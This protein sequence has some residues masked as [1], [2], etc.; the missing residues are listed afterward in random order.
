[1]P[2]NQAVERIFP[3]WARKPADAR[4][5]AFF[6]GAGLALLDA[7]L[8]E[9]PP[10][11]GALRQRLA[12]RAATACA[13]MAR[14][15]DDASGLRDAEHLAPGAETTQTSPAGRIHR[16]WR[17]FASRPLRLDGST[18]RMAADLV[19]LTASAIVIRVKIWLSGDRIPVSN[20]DARPLGRRSQ[21]K[22][23]LL[24]V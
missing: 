8:R 12:L 21:V 3:R 16:L 5:P 22:R 6:A 18:L 2:Q 19:G 23:L 14:L 13:T 11:A 17:L 7:S 10:F 24:I 9:N 20:P 15:R 1:M 4:E